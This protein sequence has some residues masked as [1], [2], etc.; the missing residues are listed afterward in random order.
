MEALK[1]KIDL[2]EVQQKLYNK[3][4]PSGWGDK[5]KTYLLSSDFKYLL[6]QLLE[7]AKAGNRF[8]PVLK[9][10]FRAFEECPYKDLKLVMVG[11]DP[12]PQPGV[13]DGIAFS[14][15]N[16]N[17]QQ[18]SLS[19]MQRE[20]HDKCL[21]DKDA[22]EWKVD[23]KSWS[24][25]GVLLLNTALTTRINKVGSHYEIW[26]TFMNF[27]FDMLAT[28][29]SGL[30]Y[31]FMGNKAKEWADR[32]PDRLNNKFF[33]SHPASAGYN[34]DKYWNTGD[35]FTKIDRIIFDRYGEYIK[36]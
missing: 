6:A 30:V 36:W 28:Q 26:R 27:L 2:D 24:N 17:Q 5:L 20:M 33:V 18:P 8:T 14:C 7:D 34:K 16:T 11:Q 32:I 15:S 4:K 13:A 25:Q 29:N 12:Y 10:V 35:T 22:Y 1:N 23:L 9:Q 31:L 21:I 19:Y 3:L